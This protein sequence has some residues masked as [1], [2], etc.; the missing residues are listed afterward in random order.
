MKCFFVMLL[1]AGAIFTPAEAKAPHMYG[2]ALGH[3]HRN[4]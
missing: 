1:M 2:A 4:M 3:L